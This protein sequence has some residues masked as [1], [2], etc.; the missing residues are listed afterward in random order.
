M[1]A[2]EIA[3]PVWVEPAYRDRE[4]VRELV[5]D[6]SP[7]ALMMSSA[8]YGEMAQQR[9]E[10]WF[11]SHWALDG[12]AV[13]DATHALLYYEPFVEAAK[14]MLGVEVVRPSTLLVNVMGPQAAGAR[15]VD[16]P[17]FRG[18]KRSEVPVWL[19][20]VMGS[21]GLFEP[22][23]VHVAGALT[24]FYERDDG[25]YEYWPHGV[26]APAEVARGPFGNVAL[27]ADNDLMPHRVAAIGDADAFASHVTV[28]SDA[29]ICVGNDGA[30]TISSS[31]GAPQPVHDRDVRISIL[32]KALTFVDDADAR[33]FDD[34][35]DDLDV[36]TIVRRLRDDL[37]AR[38]IVV[39]EPADPF[40]DPDWSRALTRT[41]IAAL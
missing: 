6:H 38:G 26:D 40:T 18:L 24:W 9:V 3:E 4:A 31:G 19:L 30:W 21:S 32:W 27:V 10:P 23:R 34:H 7:Y 41:Y 2:V 25:A 1:T 39:D 29:V 15:H 35:E 33:R 16:T 28:T 17:T 13:D 22:W 5:R 20:V 8:G 36:P 37:A 12:V 11:R 14:Q